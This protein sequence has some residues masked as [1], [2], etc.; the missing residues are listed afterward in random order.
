MAIR[1]V[2]VGSRNR[3]KVEAVKEALSLVGIDAEVVAVDVESGVSN[4]PMCDETFYGARNRAIK[5]LTETRADLGIGIEGGTCVYFNRLMGF[6][7]VYAVSKDGRESFSMS[8]WFP[9]PNSIASHILNGKELGE[10]TDI[11]FNVSGSK[12]YDGVIKYLT[13]YIT[14]KDL[15]VQAV[16]ISLYPFYNPSV[17][18]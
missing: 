6:A 17:S 12:N 10:A 5:A 15:Y 16:V 11:V 14:R 8:P 2:A 18:D 13:K 9:I 1:R 4:Q 3:A 7:V